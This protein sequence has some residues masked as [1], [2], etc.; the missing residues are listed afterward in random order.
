MS[1]REDSWPTL[2][3]PARGDALKWRENGTAGLDGCD[4][5]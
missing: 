3:W 1:N 4:E 5:S 2:G